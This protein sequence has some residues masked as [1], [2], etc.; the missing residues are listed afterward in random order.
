MDIYT[1]SHDYYNEY[2]SCTNNCPNH[3]CVAA[4]SFRCAV[5]AGSLN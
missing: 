4:S 5:N 3:F 2:P 1:S